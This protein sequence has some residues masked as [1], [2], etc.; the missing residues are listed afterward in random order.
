VIKN[1]VLKMTSLFF[2]ILILFCANISSARVF[3]FKKRSFGTYLRGTFGSTSLQQGAYQPGMV[4]GV[5]F[6]GTSGTQTAF[7]GEIGLKFIPT[8]L[9]AFRL[10]MELLAPQTASGITGLST[11]AAPLFNL[12]SQVLSYVPELNFELFLK[13]S[14]SWRFFVGGGAGYA[15]TT[16]K[17]TYTMTQL[18]VSQLGVSSYIEEGSGS[19]ILGNALLGIEMNIFDNV[20]FTLD[21]GYRYLTV[22]NFVSSR[23]STTVLGNVTTGS[24]LKNFDGT[25]RSVNLSGFWSGATFVIYIN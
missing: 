2:V 19:G 6:S 7:S 14:S 1:L 5:G 9:L 24:A 17:N 13:K 25:N 15:V 11:T 8:D 20:G 23:N 4:S 3:D 22:N 18:G 10:G 21:L 12:E 16:I